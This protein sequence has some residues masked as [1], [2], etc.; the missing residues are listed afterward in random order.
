MNVDNPLINEYNKI[1]IGLV[2]LSRAVKVYA[3]SIYQKLRAMEKIYLER[4]PSYTDIEIKKIKYFGEAFAYKFH[5]AN[6]YLEQLWSLTHLDN[7]PPALRDVLANIFDSHQ[8]NENKQLLPS[9]VFEGFIIQGKA[10]LDFYM[11]YI[12]SIF[13]IHETNHLS[14]KKLIKA[15]EYDVKEPYKSTA[16]QV[17]LYFEKNVFSGTD[18]GAFLTNNWGELLKKLRD[19]LVH[20]DIL[21][22]NFD[23]DVALLEI[24]IGK[25]PTKEI[26]LTCSRFCQ[27]IHNVMFCLVEELAATVYGL[28]W[29]PGPYKQGMW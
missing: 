23:N 19:S 16:K 18:N 20:R 10:F 28:E 14:G 8:F 17:K 21:Y 1:Y 24:I 9:I 22:P 15:L 27:D 5:L 4:N 6:M 26:D 11:L 3:T 29:I 2:D 25:W 12:C 7:H 13:K